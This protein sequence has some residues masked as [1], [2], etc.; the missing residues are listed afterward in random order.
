MQ[1]DPNFSNFLYVPGS[2]K[3]NLIDMGACNEYPQKFTTPYME[4]VFGAVT[5]D[6][7]L[8]YQKSKGKKHLNVETM[9]SDY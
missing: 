3:L 9:K 4:L 8:V 6:R 1:T 2:F 7:E 5:G